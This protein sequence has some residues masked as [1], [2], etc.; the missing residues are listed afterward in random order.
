MNPHPRSG[1]HELIIRQK[2]LHAKIFI[3][4]EKGMSNQTK[5]PTNISN[6]VSDRKPIDPPPIVQLKISESVDPSQNFLQSK[7]ISMA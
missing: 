4:K 7:T 3:G 5:N 2:P 6:S 1:D